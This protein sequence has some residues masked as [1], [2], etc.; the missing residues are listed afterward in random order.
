LAGRLRG[1]AE[2]A[3]AAVRRL[4]R[5]PCVA[6]AIANAGNQ[7]SKAAQAFARNLLLAQ[8]FSGDI[9]AAPAEWADVLVC[10]QSEPQS[11][12]QCAA[13]SQLPVVA[14]RPGWHDNPDLARRACDQLQRELAGRGDFAGYLV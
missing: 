14:W 11:L 8:E 3:E 2:P 1:A 6:L 9:E 5:W 12:A 4:A 10:N 7:I 13:R